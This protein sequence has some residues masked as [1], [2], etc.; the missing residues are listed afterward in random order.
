MVMYLILLYMQFILLC[1]QSYQMMHSVQQRGNNGSSFSELQLVR[2][3]LELH[4]AGT[5]STSSTLLTAFLYL[6]T[7]PDIQ[8]L[9][10]VNSW[11]YRQFVNLEKCPF[12][13]PN[14]MLG[15]WNS[16]RDDGFIPCRTGYT[17][18]ILF[19]FFFFFFFLLFVL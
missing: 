4:S 1:R 14:G 17:Y 19:F 18:L 12:G 3:I 2:S 6:I 11:N 10:Y 16:N 8:G 5:D 15:F 13:V 9:N 7:H